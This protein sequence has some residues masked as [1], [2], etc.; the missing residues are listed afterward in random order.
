MEHKHHGKSSSKFLSSDEILK[1][2]NFKG[3]ET[4]LDAGCG[5]GYISIKAIEE[6]LPEGEVYAIDIYE[7]SIDALNN[8][9]NENN[10]ENLSTI[11]ADLTK[12][13][14]DVKDGSIDV[15]LMLNVFHG[16]NED[17]QS[18]VIN[19]L[20]RLIKDDGKIAIMDFKPIDMPIG[21][22]MEIRI[23]PNELEEIFNNYNLKKVYLNEEIG[24]EF[25]EDKSHYLIMFEKE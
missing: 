19:E 15:I 11:V 10:L 2:F 7:E 16:F 23:S 3:N 18:D 6:Y 1:E 4:F 21:P 22:P 9:K 17:N 25:G 13:V 14:P 12:G 20:S 8:Y 24:A 5:D